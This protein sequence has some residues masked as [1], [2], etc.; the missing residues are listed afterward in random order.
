MVQ[1]KKIKRRRGRRSPPRGAAKKP[2]CKFPFDLRLK[3]VKLHLEEGVQIRLVAQEL[4]AAESTV[5]HWLRRYRTIGEDGLRDGMVR[6]AKAKL[7]PVVRQRITSIKRKHPSFGVR[8]ISQLLRRIF[9]LQASHET[10][11]RCLNEKQLIEKPSRR[12]RRN[13]PKPRFFERSQPNQL[14]QSDIF[15]FRLGGRQAYLIA[16]LDDYSRYLA[17]CGLFRSQTAEHVLEV[18]RIAVSEYGVPKE[19]LTDN[20]RQYTNWRGKT[21]F[22]QELTK[23][24]VHHIKSAPHH[25]MTLG[26]VERFWKSIW[27]EFLCRAQFG[28]FEEAQERVR[29]WVKYYNHKRPHQ[30]IGGLCPAD[31]FFE[32]QHALRQVVEQGIEENI[33]E[34]AL[35]GQPRDPFYMVG[36]MGEQSVVIRAEKGRVR[37]LVDGDELDQSRELV[38]DL[39]EK[40]H[41]KELEQKT[42]IGTARRETLLQCAGEVPGGAGDLGREAQA[43]GGLPGVGSQVESAESVAGSGDGG[44]AD[45]LGTQIEEGGGERPGAGSQIAETAGEESGTAGWKAV[46]A[47]SPPGSDTGTEAAASHPVIQEDVQQ[48]EEEV[49]S[50]IGS[51]GSIASRADLEGSQRSD[52]RPGGGETVGCEPQNLLPVGEAR[53]TG[54]AGRAESAPWG[55]PGESGGRG[56]AATTSGSGGTPPTAYAIGTGPEDPGDPEAEYSKDPALEHSERG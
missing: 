16:F 11:R 6:S 10:V 18:W 21:R 56:E 31:R 27:T 30:G 33:L 20:G 55:S 36:R 32:I 37:M 43:I 38:Y 48:N 4:G 22:E 50:A 23:D 2:P 34:M 25:P 13:P 28:S 39:K 9:C 42:A 1:S 14:W 7:S 44:D 24:R 47:G 53:F 12:P 35:R 8:R 49:P 51:G 52:D 17:G 5:H 15:T 41:E 45:R 46:Q 40:N 54:D 19:V 3:A 26:K 29:L